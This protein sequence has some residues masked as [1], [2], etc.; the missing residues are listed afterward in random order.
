MAPS[1]TVEKV[2]VLSPCVKVSPTT[3]HKGFNSQQKLF[4]QLES[5][6]SF[7]CVKELSL[8]NVITCH[9]HSRWPKNKAL[10][11]LR[12]QK[13]CDA[14]EKQYSEYHVMSCDI[15]LIVGVGVHFWLYRYVMWHFLNSGGW[16][17]TCRGTCM[18]CDIWLC[19]VVQIFSYWWLTVVKLLSINADFKNIYM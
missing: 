2:C 15:F 16:G 7:Q 11:I 6:L 9:E 10:S 12:S 1:S 13:S 19:T 8:Q 3:D 14:T 18:S 4:L 5:L 17:C